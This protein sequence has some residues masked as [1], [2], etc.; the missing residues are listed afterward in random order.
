M[1]QNYIMPQ[2]KVLATTPLQEVTEPTYGES[3]KAQSR[4]D[5]RRTS[6]NEEGLLIAVDAINGLNELMYSF[7]AKVAKPLSPVEIDSLAA[8]LVAVRRVKDIVEGREASLKAYATEVIN[9]NI[10][11]IGNDPSETSGYLVSPE[12]G[13]KLSKEVTGGKLNIDIDLLEQVLDTDQFKSVVNIVETQTITTKPDGSKLI[14]AT[15]AYQLNEECLEKEL[16]IGNIGMEQVV[17]ATMPGK[18]RS[19]FYVRSL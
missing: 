1:K 16:K 3:S 6:A 7:D 14:E 19:A 8:E 18:I 4:A 9:L 17:K 11:S 15:K 5:V 12:N 13:I 2:K 10:A